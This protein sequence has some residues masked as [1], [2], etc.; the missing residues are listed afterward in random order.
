MTVEKQIQSI[1]HEQ[2]LSLGEIETLVLPGYHDEKILQSYQHHLERQTDIHRE[3]LQQTL[4][5]L[6]HESHL[7]PADSATDN[8]LRAMQHNLSDFDNENDVQSLI[9][10]WYLASKAADSRLDE[11][12][13]GNISDA[14]TSLENADNTCSELDNLETLWKQVSQS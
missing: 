7:L 3:K 13:Q 4:N 8:D 12:V 9:I 14:T 5:L 6:S 2:G 11:N 10:R 1:K